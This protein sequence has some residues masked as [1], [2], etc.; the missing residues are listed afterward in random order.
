MEKNGTDQLANEEVLRRVN[1]G[2]QILNST[3][4]R[5]H[6]WIGCVLRHDRLLHEITE[7]RMRDEPTRKI[8]ELLHDWQMM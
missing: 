6:R 2:R 3:C 1:E 7:G 5:K 4:Q 8:N